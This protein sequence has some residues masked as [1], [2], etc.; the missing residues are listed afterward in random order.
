M[1]EPSRGRVYQSHGHRREDLHYPPQPAADAVWPP[2]VGEPP[3][4]RWRPPLAVWIVLLVLTVAGAIVSAFIY[5]GPASARG[6][7]TPN[8]AVDGFLTGIY[9][10]HNAREAGRYVCAG[11]RDDAELDQIVF[12]ARN[13]QKEY[14]AAKVTWAYPPITPTETTATVP[15]TLTL[16]TANDQVATRE[17][18]FVLVDQRGWWVCAIQTT[19]P[20][21]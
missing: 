3:R 20:A 9:T 13:A 15:V 5:I 11:S 16:T 14:T 8:E 6:T 12:D 1:T 17:V 4:R 10:T 21:R 7:R 19:D 18:T 2:V